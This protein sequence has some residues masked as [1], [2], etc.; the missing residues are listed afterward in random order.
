MQQQPYT[1]YFSPAKKHYIV[2]YR[3]GSKQ[4]TKC[5]PTHLTPDRSLVDRWVETWWKQRTV[6][7]DTSTTML[8]DIL[9]SEPV[10]LKPQTSSVAKLWFEGTALW[11]T[12]VESWT[13]AVIVDW[14]E[15]A[16]RKG[17][18]FNTVR[19]VLAFLRYVVTEA[20]GRGWINLPYNVVADEFVQ[21][22]MRRLKRGAE[23]VPVVFLTTE[24]VQRLLTVDIPFERHVLYTLA[25]T[26]GLRSAE[27]GAL[28]W[29]D[30][31]KDVLSV[32]GQLTRCN[33]L[34]AP[35]KLPKG[36]VERSVPLHPT[37]LR[38]LN[39]LRLRRNPRLRD[40][41]FRESRR[42]SVILREDLAVAGC[43]TKMRGRRISFH[44][45]RRTF[46][47]MLNE[48]QVEREVIKR[49]VG[50]A[51]GDVTS[52]HY[53]GS[54]WRKMVAAINSLPIGTNDRILSQVLQT[55]AAD[56]GSK[57]LSQI[58]ANDR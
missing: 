22:R 33:D 37:A 24:D 40:R 32:N 1:I 31:D 19:N 23:R 43:A 35:T 20:R 54:D 47:T 48:Q 58:A 6:P 2:K 5:V 7:K 29:G 18:A 41:V 9:S 38:T 30:I 57:W 44:A 4:Q 15:W 10:S 14:I 21:Q 17:R 26:T 55:A 12:P 8:S 52:G 56:D 39:E 45:L 50:H 16:A 36:G 13:P 11:T 53:I 34:S 49:I 28:T 3:E 25:V 46:I 51:V 27:L 42:S